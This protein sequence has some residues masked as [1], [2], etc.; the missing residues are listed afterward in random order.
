MMNTNEKNNEY[1]GVENGNNY[2]G[3]EKT[4]HEIYK[5]TSIE[6]SCTKGYKNENILKNSLNVNEQPYE[7]PE[8]PGSKKS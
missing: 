5:G 2:N 8:A 6:T 3:K 4:T 7:T 1:K